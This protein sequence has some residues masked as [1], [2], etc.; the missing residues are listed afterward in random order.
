MN[1]QKCHLKWLKERELKQQELKQAQQLILR[2]PAKTSTNS[3]VLDGDI[4]TNSP[5]VTDQLNIDVNSEDVREPNAS[6]T[7]DVKTI[8]SGSSSTPLPPAATP[9]SP[10]LTSLLRSPTATSSGPLNPPKGFTT[11]TSKPFTLCM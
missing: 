8:T 7:S 10:L 3:E 5:S 11:P 9:S 6:A 1:E 2:S 4:G